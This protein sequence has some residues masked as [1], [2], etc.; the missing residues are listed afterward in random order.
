MFY[1]NK[2]TQEL[3]KKR[4]NFENIIIDYFKFDGS[5]RKDILNDRIF[6]IHRKIDS[7]DQLP[8]NTKNSV[9]L[10]IRLPP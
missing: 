2:S 4:I 9:I 1:K 10:N 3:K 7:A 6:R 5:Q 8:V